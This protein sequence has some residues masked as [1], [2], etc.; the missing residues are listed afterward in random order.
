[1]RRSDERGPRPIVAQKP[2]PGVYPARDMLSKD[3]PE[4]LKKLHVFGTIRD[5]PRI[6][7]SPLMAAERAPVK[8]KYMFFKTLDLGPAVVEDAAALGTF[9]A[10]PPCR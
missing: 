4:L 2:I 5:Q 1:M 9:G 10:G 8:N 6:R 7:K 3:C